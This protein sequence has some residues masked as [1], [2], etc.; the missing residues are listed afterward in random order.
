VLVADSIAAS[1]IVLSLTGILL[2]T[3][4]LGRRL[5]AVAIALGA[6]AIAII[7]YINLP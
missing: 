3:R 5:L 1:L 4:L 2:W 7:G 6:P